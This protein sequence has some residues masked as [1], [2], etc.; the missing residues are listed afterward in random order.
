MR[1]KP[2]KG[3]NKA[4]YPNP[5]K[6][7]NSKHATSGQIVNHNSNLPVQAETKT[8]F[9]NQ[10]EAKNR[11]ELHLRDQQQLKVV[12]G[13]RSGKENG[14]DKRAISSPATS[15]TSGASSK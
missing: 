14:V 6:G 2:V 3:K 7:I 4:N 12:E 8:Y 11:D 13:F 10:K 5:V 1:S 15:L 9:V